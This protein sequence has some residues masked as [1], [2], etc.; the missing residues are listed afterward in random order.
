[1]DSPRGAYPGHTCHLGVQEQEIAERGIIQ[2]QAQAFFPADRDGFHQLD[3]G[4]QAVAQAIHGLQSNLL[5]VAGDMDDIRLY[6]LRHTQDFIYVRCHG[7]SQAAGGLGQAGCHLVRLG[8][9]QLAVYQ[10]VVAGHEANV[11][12]A[13]L[14]SLEGFGYLGKGVNLDQHAG[15]QAG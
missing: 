15:A 13:Q 3:L 5:R 14:G 10:A 2:G 6:R 1:M 4:G 7:Q 12:D 9:A 8:E 11:I